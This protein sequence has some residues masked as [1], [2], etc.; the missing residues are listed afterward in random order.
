MPQVRRA[1]PTR[2]RFTDA[3]LA[4]LRER[5]R[6]AR[7]PLA[8]YIREA[9]LGV[10]PRGSGGT[11]PETIRGLL[12]V[13]TALDRLAGYEPGHSDGLARGVSLPSEERTAVG[14]ALDAVNA[15]VA[16]I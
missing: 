14:A 4:T 11:D 2:V 8:R 13:A 16:R 7:R 15:L 5:A 12:R 6:A 10:A 3:E 1:N 9:A